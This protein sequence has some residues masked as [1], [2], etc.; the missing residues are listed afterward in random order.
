MYVIHFPG[1]FGGYFNKDRNGQPYMSVG[2]AD[3]ATHYETMEDAVV[4]LEL[5]RKARCYK[6]ASRK[7]ARIIYDRHVAECETDVDALRRSSSNNVKMWR[8]GDPIVSENQI[9][10]TR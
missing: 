1:P 10:P 9:P 6:P 3:R 8:E 4:A 2:A 5:V 7:M